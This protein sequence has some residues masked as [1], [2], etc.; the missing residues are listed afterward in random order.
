ME[1]TCPI[2]CRPAA[3]PYRRYNSRGQVVEGCVAAFHGGKLVTP[4][5]SNRWHCR[6]ATKS[7]RRGLKKYGA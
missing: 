1:A 4:S 7:I 2:C 6:P 5:E 3:A